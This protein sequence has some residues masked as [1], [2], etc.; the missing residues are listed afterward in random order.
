M[1]GFP[2]SASFDL[3]QSVGQNPTLEDN[4]AVFSHLSR[5]TRI[6]RVAQ[7]LR[8][9]EIWNIDDADLLAHLSRP[10]H[11]LMLTCPPEF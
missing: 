2:R 6:L 7:S 10:V 3:S 5:A 9:C 4:P 8:F 11:A 1:H